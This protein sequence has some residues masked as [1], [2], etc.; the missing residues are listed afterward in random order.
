MES[1]KLFGTS[2]IRGSIDRVDARLALN[3]GRALGTMLD[4]TGVVAVGND[5]RTS[6]APLLNAFRAGMNSTGADV[7]ILGLVPMP[8]TAFSSSLSGITTSVMITASH[9]PPTDNG[10]KFFRNG[11]EFVREEENRIEKIIAERSFLTASWD[12]LGQFSNYSIRTDYFQRLNAFLATR[13]SRADGMRVLIDLANGAAVYYTPLLLR[14]M[15][16]SV[17][18]VNSHPDGHFPGRLP[19]PSPGNLADT[20]RMAQEMDFAVT[21]CHDGDGDRL[22]VI[23]EQGHFIDQNRIIAL[24]ARDELERH[25]G[26]TVVVSIDTSSVIDEIVR[27]MGGNLVR[28]PLGSLQQALSADRSR[29]IVFAS[30]PWKPIFTEIG[31]WMDG[32][33]GAAR[34]A[35]M[36][37]ELGA[38]SCVRL[39]KSV[40][41]YPMLREQILCP[42]ELKTSF[43]SIVKGLLKSE[44]TD[45]NQ[46]LEVDGIRVDRSDGSYVLVRVSGTE[47]KARVYIGARNQQT[48]DQLA[49]MAKDIMARSL[50]EARSRKK[51][52]GAAA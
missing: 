34:M 21:L 4:G 23:D 45:I 50:D 52:P 41:E 14:D 5:A 15:G 47:P 42:D 19:E 40:P 29:K 13:G 16:F 2:G 33:A 8:V 28:V 35:Q 20:M 46:I 51:Q 17:I 12:K 43:M 9:N 38:G 3:L 10:F 37:N 11:R 39:M 6:R 36:V 49:S 48:L 32:I 30:E 26:G 31:G 44:L 27:S 25:G 24:F 22:A 18:T 7:S 1:P